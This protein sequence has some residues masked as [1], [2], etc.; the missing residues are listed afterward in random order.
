MTPTQALAPFVNNPGYFHHFKDYCKERI[1]YFKTRLETEKDRDTILA[2]QGSIKELRRM[3]DLY[4]IVQQ[5]VKGP[6]NG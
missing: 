4:E 6:S 3:L 5:E 2:Y 1:D